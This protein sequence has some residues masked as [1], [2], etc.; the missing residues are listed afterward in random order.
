MTTTSQCSILIVGAPSVAAADER[1]GDGALR[2]LEQ[3]DRHLPGQGLV[4]VHDD[5]PESGDPGDRAREAAV[6]GAALGRDE[7]V[8]RSVP[9][10]LSRF[11]LLARVLELMRAPLGVIAGSVDLVVGAVRTSALLA[12]VAHLEDPNPSLAQH[13][14]GLFPG[15]CFLVDGGTVAAVKHRL[16][17]GMGRG[18]EAVLVTGEVAVADW[19]DRLW[20]SVGPNSD[21][22]EPVVLS[23]SSCWGTRRWAE[24]SVMQVPAV[25]LAAQLDQTPARSCIWCARPIAA[26]QP[27]P[28]CGCGTIAPSRRS[29][30]QQKDHS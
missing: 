6:A 23:G 29:H 12:S 27:C 30:D 10:P 11:L 14:R 24:I 28:F 15:G 17:R 19:P 1:G 13:A 18:V 8:I 22:P 2:V 3:V 25:Q 7:I 20:S 26:D 16:P 21:R 9:G 4:L 5:R